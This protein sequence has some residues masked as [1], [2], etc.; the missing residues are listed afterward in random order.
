MFQYL[1]LMRSNKIKTSCLQ[2]WIF[3]SELLGCICAINQ[4]F[5][6]HSWPNG[7]KGAICMSPP[8]MPY[9][10]IKTLLMHLIPPV[11]AACHFLFIKK[12]SINRRFKY[13]VLFK[14]EGKAKLQNY[15]CPET[16]G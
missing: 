11:G 2:V 1:A 6:M 7:H 3:G 16:L 9:G 4:R 8:M 10:R 14:G 13:R 5:W 12:M 15:P